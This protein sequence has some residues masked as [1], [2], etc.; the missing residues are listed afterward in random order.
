LCFV[1]TNVYPVCASLLP[2]FLSTFTFQPD[3]YLPL[4]IS[5]LSI[6]LD[7]INFVYAL[8]VFPHSPFLHPLHFPFSLPLPSI[9]NCNQHAGIQIK[10][11]TLASVT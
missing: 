6:L 3:F 8:F 1:S 5:P 4:H 9:N 2:F 7:F 11:E 10:H